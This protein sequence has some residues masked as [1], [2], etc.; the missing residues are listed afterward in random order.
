MSGFV[1]ANLTFG[2]IYEAKTQV[3]LGE[4]ET[5]PGKMVFFYI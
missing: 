1:K 4:R 2:F 3:D 5:A